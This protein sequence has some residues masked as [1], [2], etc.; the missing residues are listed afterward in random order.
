MQRM[1]DPAVHRGLGGRQRLPQDLAAENLRLAEGRYKAGIGD[2]L[3]FNDAQLLF[4]QNQ[5]DLVVTYYT[6][7]TALARIERAAGLTPELAGI[8]TETMAAQN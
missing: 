4:T 2:L 6:Y 8:D 5:S 3:E 7:L 1:S